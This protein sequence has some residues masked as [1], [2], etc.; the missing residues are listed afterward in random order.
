MIYYIA[1]SLR[2]ED[3][4]L[5]GPENAFSDLDE[6][7][8]ARQALED[9]MPISGDDWVVLEE[10]GCAHDKGHEDG[11]GGLVCR[12]CGDRWYDVYAKGVRR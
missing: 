11:Y 9:T 5:A 2:S 10:D 4:D 7:N 6:A 12:L 8:A 1:P 3:K